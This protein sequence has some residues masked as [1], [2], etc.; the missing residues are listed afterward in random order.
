MH[1]LVRLIKFN[2]DVDIDEA[3]YEW[4]RQKSLQGV[5]ISAPILIGKARQITLADGR[6]FTLSSSWIQRWKKRHDISWKKEEGERQDADYKSAEDW[7]TFVLPD[8]LGQFNALD[9]FNADETALYYCGFPDRGYGMKNDKLC[10]G[11][12]RKTA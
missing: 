1:S 12:K 11:K 5:Q 6:E 7:I 9:I 10:G 4:F 3:L 8:L 2:T